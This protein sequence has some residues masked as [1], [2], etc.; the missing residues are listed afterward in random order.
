M[1]ATTSVL[2]REIVRRVLHQAI[3]LCSTVLIKERVHNYG[4]KKQYKFC[5]VLAE[6]HLT[7]RGQ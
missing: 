1:V 6:A 3:G 4:D 2:A 7:L 5:C